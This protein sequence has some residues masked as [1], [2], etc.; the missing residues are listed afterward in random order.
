MFVFDLAKSGVSLE[1]RQITLLSF[2]LVEFLREEQSSQCLVLPLPKSPVL[3]VPDA[4][5]YLMY[6]LGLNIHSL[7]ECV[8]GHVPDCL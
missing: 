4:K 7:S 2:L 3:F 6:I 1:K 5:L 8:F